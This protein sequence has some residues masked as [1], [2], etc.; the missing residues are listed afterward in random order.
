MNTSIFAL[1]LL[2]ELGIGTAVLLIIPA[3]FISIFRI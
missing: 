2:V 1:H 3:I